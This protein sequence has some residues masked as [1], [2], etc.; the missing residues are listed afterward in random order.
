MLADIKG[1]HLDFLGGP[2]SL[3]HGSDVNTCYMSLD[4]SMHVPHTL[5]PTFCTSVKRDIW[6]DGLH[7]DKP[8]LLISHSAPLFSRFEAWRA[9][10]F[11]SRVICHRS[12]WRFS[13]IFRIR[14]GF[15]LFGSGLDSVW[16][17]LQSDH[18][19]NIAFITKTLQSF[20]WKTEG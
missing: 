6:C 13:K 7:C 12:D 14:T 4:R 20:R 18:L 8:R 3:S 11:W 9:S 2:N 16:K 15:N 1:P 19:C 17:I 10:R 5:L